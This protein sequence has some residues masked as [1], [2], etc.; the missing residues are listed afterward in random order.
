MV[1]REGF[2]GWG[3]LGQNERGENNLNSKKRKR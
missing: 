2:S 1:L 3:D